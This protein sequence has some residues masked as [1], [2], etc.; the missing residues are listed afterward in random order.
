ML[1]RLLAFIDAV[2]AGIG[3][4]VS[5]AIF[6]MIAAISFEVVARYFFNAPTPWVQDVSGWLQVAYVFLGGAFALQTGHFV[7]VDVLYARLP[8]RVQALIDLV[9]ATA[10]FACFATVIIWKGTELAYQSVRMGEIS[11]T[12]GWRGPIYP[13]KIIIPI[14]MALVALAWLTHALRQVR[15]LLRPDAER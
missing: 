4:V 5:L 1:D 10:L 9:L 3:R 7:R 13:A 6:V 11:A 14:G 8:A 15:I 12:G 2:I